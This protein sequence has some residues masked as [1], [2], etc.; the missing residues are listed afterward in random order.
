MCAGSFFFVR[1]CFSIQKLVAFQKMEKLLMEIG[2]EL[3]YSHY[4]LIG[5]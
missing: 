5:I 3:S 1:L 4:F 2:P